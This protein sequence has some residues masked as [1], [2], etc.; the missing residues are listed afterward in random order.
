VNDL[1]AVAIA[2]FPE[3]GRIKVLLEELGARAAQMSGSG[4]AVF[5]IFSTQSAADRAAEQARQRMPDATIMSA[6]TVDAG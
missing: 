2:Q 4:G 1:A 6:T 5:G 3:I